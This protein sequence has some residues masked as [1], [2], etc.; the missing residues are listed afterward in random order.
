MMQLDLGTWIRFAVWMLIG[1]FKR[2]EEYVCS[3]S[4]DFVNYKFAVALQGGIL[5]SKLLGDLCDFIEAI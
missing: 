5:H 3:K 4:W 1:E 2:E